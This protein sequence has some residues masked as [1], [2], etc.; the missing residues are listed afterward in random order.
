MKQFK[1]RWLT[2][3]D[4]IW[5]RFKC[6]KIPNFKKHTTICSNYASLTGYI[7]CK[8]ICKS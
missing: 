6:A 1:S 2:D 7:Y 8:K 3:K 5:S 4:K